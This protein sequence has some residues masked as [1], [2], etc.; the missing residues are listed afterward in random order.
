MI[1]LGIETSG[2]VG[3]VAVCS[4]DESLAVHVFPPGPRHARNLLPAV[5]DVIRRAGLHKAQVDAVAVSQGPG[6]FTGLRVG[7]ACAK[8]LAFALGWQCVGV[9]SLEVLVQNAPA[10]ADGAV[11]CPV[12]NARR[13]RVYGTI[14]QGKHGAWHDMTGV[15][16]LAPAELAG[17]LPDGAAVFGSGV[18]AYPARFPSS[19]FTVGPTAYGTGRAES[20]ARLGRERILAGEADDPA[21][22]L[23]KY[24]R[25]TEAEERFGAAVKQ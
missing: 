19:R 21:A 14:F 8:T 25:L 17:R 9:P 24:Y 11:A 10:A 5:D 16:L 20:V 15:L 18:D 22:L 4:D 7:V 6:S 2:A 12:R 23:P 1:V 3:S 13:E